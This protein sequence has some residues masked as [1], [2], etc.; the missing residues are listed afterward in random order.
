MPKQMTIDEAKESLVDLLALIYDGTTPLPLERN[1]Q[2]FAVVISPEQFEHYGELSKEDFFR[3]VDEIRR[4]N[5]DK[6]P[7]EV[8]RDVT[9]IVEEVRQERYEREAGQ[10]RVSLGTGGF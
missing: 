9:E 4:D 2:P 7:D 1:G 5:Q 3:I 10:G 6:D 8:L